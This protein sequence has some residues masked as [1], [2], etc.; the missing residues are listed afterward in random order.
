MQYFFYR[1]QNYDFF[2]SESV[3]YKRNLQ[4]N[5]RQI[6]VKVMAGGR[7]PLILYIG[8]TRNIRWYRFLVT[9]TCVAFYL[10]SKR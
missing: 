8:R 4:R 1:A 3:R 7:S 5:K 9:Y 6:K 2:N 10:V